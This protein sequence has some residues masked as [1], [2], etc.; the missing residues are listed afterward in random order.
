MNNK[1][2]TLIELMIV[3]SIIGILSSIAIPSY[4]GYIISAQLTEAHTLAHQLKPSIDEY[5]KAHGRFP[6]NNKEAGLPEAKYL[7]GNY[8]KQIEVEGGVI[9]VT[10]GNKINQS[11]RDKVLSLQPLVVI[12]SPISP[13]SWNCGTAE[14]PVGMK[15]VGLDRTSKDITA[16]PAMCR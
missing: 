6:Q 5:Y 3:V 10:L 8:V 7:I 13:I 12:N 15:T 9:H 4:N 11:L 16:L 2:F 1:G 14:P